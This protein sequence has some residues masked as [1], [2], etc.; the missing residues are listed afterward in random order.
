MACR[1]PPRSPPGDLLSR[2]ADD[3]NP[4]LRP[5]R[6]CSR[7]D[8]CRLGDRRPATG[9]VRGVDAA[10]GAGFLPLL[11]RH[12]VRRRHSGAD[13]PASAPRADRG[14]PASPGR[15]PAQLPGAG[16][17][18]LRAGSPVGPAAY[19]ARPRSPAGAAARATAGH[20]TAGAAGGR[21]GLAGP[22]PVHLGFDRRSEGRRPRPPQRA[23]QHPRL[24]RRDRPVL[25]RR[26]RQLAAAV[27]RHGPDRRLAG[28][29]VLR[30][31]AGAAVA[32]GLPGPS[33]VLA[34]GHSPP[35][36]HGRGGAEL[37]L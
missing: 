35:S 20:D 26:L 4:D 30:L 2:R 22:D 19:R 27:S 33:G 6:R 34:V 32:A 31:P 9:T 25:D 7:T 13:V 15:H 12:P 11:L 23:R 24:G 14:P 17:D 29:P 18:H 36:R 5:A 3:R 37:R 1:P 28:Q 16:A 8:R 10:L 21:S